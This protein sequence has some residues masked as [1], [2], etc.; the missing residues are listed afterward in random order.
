MEIG[1]AGASLLNLS[2]THCFLL[3]RVTSPGI[4]APLRVLKALPFLLGLIL[5]PAPDQRDDPENP[6]VL[7]LHDRQEA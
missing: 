3:K 6:Y 5:A 4:S 7:T 1:P 2:L